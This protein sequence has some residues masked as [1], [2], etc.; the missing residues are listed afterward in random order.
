MRDGWRQR[1]GLNE[2]LGTQVSGK[3]LG[4]VGIGRIG[5]AVAQ[6]AR[7]FGMKVLYNDLSRLP[8]H[9]EQEALFHSDLLE[10]LPHVQFLSLHAPSSPD[11]RGLLDS[12]AIGKLPRGAI[13]VNAARGDL[14]DEDALIEGLR[15]GHIAAAGL[16]VF[17]TEPDF[18]L[19]FLELPNVFLTPHMASATVETRNAMGF[20]ALDNIKAVWRGDPAPDNV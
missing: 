2:L 8:E 14:I 13:I 11:A 15:S 18:D 4:I 5:R 16:D 12:E 3:T 17:R 6:R 20:R 10:M 9:L 19:R 1:R 7:G